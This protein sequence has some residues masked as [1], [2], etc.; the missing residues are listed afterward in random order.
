VY[1]AFH[2]WPRAQRWVGEHWA[3]WGPAI[4]KAALDKILDRSSTLS[5]VN[6]TP[7]NAGPHLRLHRPR[8]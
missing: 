8:E 6:A 1:S 4:A 5:S 3:Q 7:I 2:E